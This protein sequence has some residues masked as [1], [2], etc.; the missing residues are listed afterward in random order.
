MSEFKGKSVLITGA[1][2]GIGRA[3]AKAFAAQGA[4]LILVARNLK[5]LQS[6]VNELKPLQKQFKSKYS[7][8]QLDLQDAKAVDIFFKKIKLLDFAINNAGVEGKISE[9]QALTLKDYHDVFDINV[10]ALFQCL[11]HEVSFFRKH[12]CPGAIVNVSSILGLRGI[13]GSSLYVASKHAVIGFTRATAVEQIAHRIR[14]NC[15]SPGAT[16]TPMLRR[17]IG[18]ENVESVGIAPGKELIKPENIAKSIT[19]LCSEESSRIVGHN[20]IVDSGRTVQIG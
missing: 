8:H 17:V 13:S 10:R 6:L 3:T 4:N 18:T 7:V 5:R 2:E 19:W 11:Q 14:I 1:S 16:D 9:I 20:L 15:I 12:A